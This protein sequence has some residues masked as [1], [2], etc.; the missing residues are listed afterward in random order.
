MRFQKILL[1]VSLVV[2]ALCTVFAWLFCSGVFAN[3]TLLITS[4]TINSSTEAEHIAK[5]YEV[6]Q[7]FTETFQVLG[8][9]LILVVVLLFIAGCH[10]RRKYYIT[11]YVAI[12]IAVVYMLVYAIVLFSSLSNIVSVLN[13][14]DFTSEI[15][16]VRLVDE[17]GS[18][19]PTTQSIA[20]YYN[21]LYTTTFGEF[22]TTSWTIPVGYVLAVIVIADAAVIVLNLVWKLKLMQGEKKLLESGLVKEVA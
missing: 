7:A 1:T 4:N 3:V 19:Y 17:Y 5:L 6:S 14:V 2:A 13:T 22:Q 10:S 16:S 20:E 21:S 15:L 18:P 9:V 12:G 11:N 8:I